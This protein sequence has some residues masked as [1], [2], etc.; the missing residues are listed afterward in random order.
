MGSTIREWRPTPTTG[1]L[2]L[3]E[4]AALLDDRTVLVTV[5]HASN[6]IGQENDIVRISAMAHA[7]GRGVVVDGVSFAPHSLPDVAAL[8]AD[9][10]LFSLYKTYSVHQGLMVVR[11]GLLD[12]LPNQSH[13]FND[14]VADKRLNPA[15]PDHAQ[16]AAA[17]AVLDYVVALHVHHGGSAN[18]R[19]RPAASSVSA[20]WRAHE[21]SLTPRLLDALA[22]RDDV[23]LLGPAKV[24]TT[25]LHRCPTVAFV[26][27]HLEPRDVAHALVQRGVQTSSGHYYAAR[28]LDGLG[29]DPDRG[30]GAALLRALHIARRSRPGD[31]RARRGARLST[32]APAAGSVDDTAEPTALLERDRRVWRRHPGDVA[33]LVARSVLLLLGLI[34]TAAVPG[35]LRDISQNVVNLFGELPDAVRYAL[36]GLAQL[37]IVAIPLAVIAWLILRRSWLETAM[38]VGAGVV[39]G[40]VMALLTDW[41]ARAAPP[42][43]SGL[44]SASFLPTDFPSS[45]YLAALVAGTA[46]AAPLMPDAWRRTCWLAVTIAV[47]VRFMSATETPVNV[48]VTVVLG[49]VIGS[50]VL[51]AFGSPRRRPGAASLHADLAAGGFVVDDLRDESEHAGRRS[52]RGS[53]EGN[54][55]AV[56][57]LDRDDR[58]V[59]LLARVVRTIRVRDVDEQSL[60]VRP[61]QRVQHEAVVTMMALQAGA[62][63]P[64][65]HAV[66][67][68]A[69]ESAVIALDVAAGRSLADLE[70]PTTCARGGP[71]RP[72]AAARSAASR[73]DRAPRR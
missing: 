54:E 32:V 69:R 12:E 73:P 64:M 2:D 67:P 3:D 8:D 43:P 37:T 15:G 11:N 51:V 23:R 18:D 25:G 34:I 47:V 27:L 29:V 20:L 38:V 53:S 56:V 5:P 48:I 58:D 19:L 40:I 68:A 10:Y 66:V 72:L 59:D 39:G 4:L 35:T 30:R 61:L 28:V 24:A 57:Y 21:D 50:V 6:I 70:R 26:P 14:G 42:V 65:V 36:I 46:T 45:A 22:D 41:L 55:I 60:S 62:R 7:V 33:R 49:S 17:G 31:R 52:Y 13:F 1:L 16:V 71:R 63:V 9:V 44:D